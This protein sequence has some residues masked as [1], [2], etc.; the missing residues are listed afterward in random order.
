MKAF[1]RIHM[2]SAGAQNPIMNRPLVFLNI[3]REGVETSG[4]IVIELVRGAAVV[5]CF[6]GTNT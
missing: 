2:L 1:K 3:Y 5:S 4:I 6:A